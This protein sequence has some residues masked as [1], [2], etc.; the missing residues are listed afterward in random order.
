MAAYQTKAN[1]N[2]HGESWA[3]MCSEKTE[4]S[5]D[6]ASWDASCVAY[7]VAPN[8]SCSKDRYA[9]THAATWAGLA[10]TRHLPNNLATCVTR[11]LYYIIK[12]QGGN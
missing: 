11:A 6:D 9:A 12:A 4:N 3:L 8:V 1:T 7:E 5:A 2:G 10:T